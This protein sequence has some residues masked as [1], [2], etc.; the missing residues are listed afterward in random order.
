[1]YYH[2]EGMDLAGKS[3]ASKAVLSKLGLT[4]QVRHNTIQEKSNFHKVVDFLR[5]TKR[6]DS[7]ELGELYYQV[8]KDDISRF[9][10]PTSYTI[11]DSTIALRSLAWYSA[12]GNPIEHRFAELLNLHPRFTNSIVLTARIDVRQNRLQSR[13]EEAP[14]TV[15]ADDMLVIEN[16][17]LFL[18]MEESLV[19]YSVKFFGSKVLDTSDLTKAEVAS[20]VLLGLGL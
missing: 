6:A 18:K 8:L 5:T 4:T 11:Q 3:T 12:Q 10:F 13:I 16:P 20:K 2:I 1:M 7:E 14:E 19:H 17:D 9:E 15:A